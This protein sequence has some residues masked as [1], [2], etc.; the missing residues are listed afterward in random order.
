MKALRAHP[1]FEGDVNRDA[2][3]LL[4]RHNYIGTPHSIYKGL[5]KL[6]PGH[7][8]RVSL[9]QPD[10]VAAPYWTGGRSDEG[11][12]YVSHGSAAGISTTP[13]WTLLGGIAN[14]Y[15]GSS[16]DAVGDVNDDGYEDLA[17]G[18]VGHS[19]GGIVYILYGLQNGVSPSSGW[20]T[21]STE[22]SALFGRPDTALGDIYA[23]G[24]AEFAVGA[25]GGSGD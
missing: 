7:L 4:L 22:T 23:E 3:A 14:L 19:S 21:T 24:F 6:A 5:Y 20:S 11:K 9:A 25:G 1:A 2:L 12:V 17:I 18:A 8:L 16:L 10:P 15:L 13:G